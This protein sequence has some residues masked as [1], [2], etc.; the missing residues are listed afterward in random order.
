MHPRPFFWGNTVDVDALSCST[1]EVS[2]SRVA[3]RFQNCPS[4]NQAQD[5]SPETGTAQHR[6]LTAG[7][8]QPNPTIDRSCV[9]AQSVP[10]SLRHGTLWP[11]NRPRFRG[12]PNPHLRPTTE[13]RNQLE[14]RCFS[15]ALRD[16]MA[17]PASPGPEWHDS[18]T[19]HATSRQRRQP[20]RTEWL[21]FLPSRFWEPGTVWPPRVAGPGLWAPHFSLLREDWKTCRWPDLTPKTGAT[22]HHAHWQGLNTI[23]LKVSFHS[24]WVPSLHEVGR[25]PAF[26]PRNTP[27][28]SADHRPRKPIA[29]NALRFGRAPLKLT[30]PTE[31]CALRLFRYTQLS[32]ARP[33]TIQKSGDRSCATAHCVLHHPV[34]W[35]S[36]IP[37]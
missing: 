18:W 17:P 15:I 13:H 30:L 16:S 11:H 34:P 33:A 5:T 14:K 23:S 19:L 6:G 8:R 37:L 28:V 22:R 29:R 10:P 7:A 26:T 36:Q 25:T 24:T 31:A 3:K 12:I 35:H 20:S 9:M 2:P 21:P 1:Y 32:S 27:A 4:G